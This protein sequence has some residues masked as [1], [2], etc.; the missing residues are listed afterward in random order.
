MRKVQR[1]FHAKGTMEGAGV[2]LHRGFSHAETSLFDPFLLFDDFSSLDSEDYL[3][4]FPWHPHRGIETVSYIIKGSVKHRDSIGNSGIITDGS[5]QWM[6]AG[7]GIIHEEMPASSNGIMGF[8]L[9]VN[10]PAKDKMMHP[11]Y[12]DIESRDIPSVA[13]SKDATAKIVAGTIQTTTG[14]VQDIMASPSFIDVT[15]KP[16]KSVQLPVVDGHTVFVYIFDGTVSA[17]GH[18]ISVGERNI[19]LFERHGEDIELHAGGAGARFLVVSGR[20]L[21]EP[22]AWYGPIVM[23]TQAELVTSVEDLQAGTFL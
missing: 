23:N 9:W 13:L 2:R 11:R 16:H 20:P 19:L 12:Q 17:E 18:P 4:G 5:V 15:L 21:H 7:K 10:I 6:T 22:I 14:P 1:V 3:A 8:Q